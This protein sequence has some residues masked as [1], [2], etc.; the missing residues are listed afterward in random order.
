MGIRRGAGQPDRL[1]RSAD[2]LPQPR[3]GPRNHL[4]AACFRAA[5]HPD[6][7]RQHRPRRHRQGAVR[8]G[9]LR[10]A[11]GAVGMSAI[12]KALDKVEAKAKKVAAFMLEAAEGDIE[13][14]DGKFTVAG[15]DKSVGLGRG[16]AQRLCRAQVHRR[17][18]RAGTEGRRVLRPDQLH[19]P[20]RLPHLR[21]RDRSRHRPRRA[22][23]AGPRSTISARSSIR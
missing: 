22:S 16:D 20:G 4:R 7:H 18:A 8:H 5:R 13:F 17:T 9:H 1:G 2:R 15:T 21:G 23:P 11:L 10:L 3:P 14:K 12:V 19:V 6:R